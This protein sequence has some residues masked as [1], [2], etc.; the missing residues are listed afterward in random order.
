MSSVCYPDSLCASYRWLLYPHKDHLH[1]P[2][3]PLPSP[4]ES[5][6]VTLGELLRHPWEASAS[7]LEGISFRL[8]CLIVYKGTTSAKGYCAYPY[9]SLHILPFL[10]IF[11][12]RQEI[13]IIF[14]GE[15]YRDYRDYSGS[16]RKCA[17]SATS[18]GV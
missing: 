2:W 3:K 6:R 18:L 17:I 4:L 7:P 16:P 11:L 15:N 5:I 9:T 8:T 1:A 14:A 10:F 13:F 12:P